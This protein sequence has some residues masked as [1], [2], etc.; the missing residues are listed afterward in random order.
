MGNSICN[1]ATPNGAVSLLAAVAGGTAGYALVQRLALATKVGA[2]LIAALTV[3][4]PRGRQSAFG[5][6]WTCRV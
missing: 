3:A 5:V 2:L 1:H 6:D 4:E